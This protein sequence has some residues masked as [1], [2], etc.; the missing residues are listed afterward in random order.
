VVKTGPTGLVAT[1]FN[2]TY[3]ISVA[4]H[5]TSDASSVTL[6]DVLPAGMTFVSM[7]QTSGPAFNC[8]GTTTV[9]CTIG[10]LINGASAAFQ[11]TVHD[12]VAAG[13]TLSNTAAISST[14]PDPNTANNSS[15]SSVSVVETIPLLSP[16]ALMLLALALAAGAWIAMRKV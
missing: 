7:S 2:V 9:T 1:G 16:S 11:L 3:D 6:T 8:S 4:N 13:T 14:T 15:T 12:N 5:G 10:T